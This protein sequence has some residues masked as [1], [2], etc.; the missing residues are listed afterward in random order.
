[1][2]RIHLEDRDIDGRIII[3]GS[4]RS[5]MKGAWSGLLWLRIGTVGRSL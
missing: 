4:S 1:M 3:K 5:G 2:R